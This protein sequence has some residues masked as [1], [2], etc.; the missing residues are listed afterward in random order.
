MNPC[1]R[2]CAEAKNS[3][4]CLITGMG[5]R[6]KGNLEKTFKNVKRAL[7]ALKGPQKLSKGILGF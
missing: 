1:A 7:K 2:P 4:V 6:K 3:R 5:G